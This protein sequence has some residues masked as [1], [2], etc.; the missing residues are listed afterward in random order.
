MAW[1]ISKQTITDTGI[2]FEMHGDKVDS[3]SGLPLDVACT[4][5]AFEK[6]T[7]DTPPDI[8][9]SELQ[10]AQ[11]S[12]MQQILAQVGDGTQIAPPIGVL[13]RATRA[14]AA[15]PR[16]VTHTAAAAAGAGALELALHLLP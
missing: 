15:A 5:V 2:Q 16:A 14:I 3:K 1:T 10:A 11:A 6:P 12:A 13:T 7:P 9:A 4:F 8:S